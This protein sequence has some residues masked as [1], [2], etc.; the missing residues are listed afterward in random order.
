MLRF[1]T[2]LQGGNGQTD[3]T[4]PTSLFGETSAVSLKL[5]AGTTLAAGPYIGRLTYG[6]QRTQQSAEGAQGFFKHILDT[7]HELRFLPTDHRPLSFEVDAGAGWMPNNR[8]LPVQEAFY[9]GNFVR[10]FVPGDPWDVRADPL[11]R[12]Y[13]QRSVDDGAG[14]FG[15]TRFASLNA[16]AAFT[17]WGRP[18]VPEEVLADEGFNAAIKGQL[19]TAENALSGDYITTDAGFTA[20]AQAVA[21]VKPD[22]PAIEQRLRRI[23]EG[24]PAESQP[25]ADDA[26]S[27]LDDVNAAVESAMEP[28]VAGASPTVAYR[29]LA[30]GFGAAG[31]PTLTVLATDLRELKP[32]VGT[33]DASWLEATAKRFEALRESVAVDLK[34]IEGRAEARARK[35][36]A[37]ARRVVDS[38]LHQVNIVSVS[39]LAMFDVAKFGWSE[40]TPSSVRYSAGPGIRLTL[41]NVNFSVG[42]S[43]NIHRVSNAPRGALLF[44]FSVSDLFR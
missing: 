18:L 33:E 36:L 31:P 37:F 27:S 19:T 43:F 30:L 40:G 22:V 44:Q 28:P 26:I 3:A 20:M 15:A 11:F 39:P 6:L 1:G 29:T 23:R 4:A 32:L 2:A 9:G 42:Y 41:V 12:G 5:Y 21:S 35:E 17:V 38:L 16:T 34:A 24:L 8:V 10:P 14:A 13:P 25:K 7:R